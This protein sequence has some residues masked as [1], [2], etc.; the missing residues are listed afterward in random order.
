MQLD[1]TCA[2]LDRPAYDPGLWPLDSRVVFLN[3][4]SFGSCPKPVLEFQREMQLRMERQPVDFFVRELEP[5]LDQARAA[6]AAFVGAEADNLMFVTNATAGVNTVLRSL[7]L[8]AGD[9]LL[10]TNHEYNACRNALDYAAA[11][12][13]ATVRVARIPFPLR[14]VD[15]I[16][17][18]VLAA[19]TPRTRLALV[20]HVSSQTGM[21]FPVELLA[22]ELAQRGIDTLVDGAHAP[23]MLPL[24]LEQLG[25]AYYT[26]NCHKWICAPKGAGFLYVR[27]DRQDR[28]RPLSISHGANSSRADRSRF[29]IE[30]GWTGTWDPSAWLS[31]PEALR[32]MGSLLPGGWPEVMRHNRRLALAGRSVLCGVLGIEPPCPEDW[33]GALAAVPLPDAAGGAP[34]VSPLYVDPLQDRLREAGNIEV[35]VIPWPEAPKRVLRISRSFTTRCRNTNCWPERW[36]TSW[37]SLH[38]LA[39]AHRSGGRPSP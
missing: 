5:L 8:G 23:G 14:S 35:P 18:P 13:G 29:L 37:D 38:P 22:R 30:F 39:R 33:I 2:P 31:V 36:R 24:N 17:E 21:V 32:V 10:V 34:P 26:G 25:A 20:D 15:Q 7:A 3:H 19:A 11:R 27:R 12:A 16:L 28:V 6:V 1:A 4:G 9:E